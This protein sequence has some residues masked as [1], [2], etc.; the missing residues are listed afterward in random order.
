LKV[1]CPSGHYGKECLPCS[2]CSGNGACKGNG[3]RKGNGKCNC[4]TGYAGEKCQSCSEGF[5][6]AFKDETKLI[7]SQCH[8]ACHGGCSGPGTKNCAKCKT[9]WFMKEGEG[10]FDVNECVD[11]ESCPDRS[12]FCVNDEGSYSCLKCDKSCDG[13][14]GDG[15]DMCEKCA[16]GYELREGMCAGELLI[17]DKIH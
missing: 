14:D 10:C 11:R 5:Y 6:E 12:E 13:C 4:D 8:V 17:V 15:P 2:E 7:C 9:G 16:D 1:C 3:T